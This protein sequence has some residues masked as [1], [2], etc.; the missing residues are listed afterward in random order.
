MRALVRIWETSSAQPNTAYD[1]PGP[2]RI[3]FSPDSQ[4]LAASGPDQAVHIVSLRTTG[5]VDVLPGSNAAFSPTPRLLATT[6]PAGA[7][8]WTLPQGA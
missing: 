8:L 2:T 4:F 1:L 6:E 3:A 7:R 5:P